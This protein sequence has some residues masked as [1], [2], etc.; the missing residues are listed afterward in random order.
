M[1][2]EIYL[3]F[4]F[5]LAKVRQVCVRAHQDTLHELLPVC[6]SKAQIRNRCPSTKA[7]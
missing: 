4:D 5:K 6:F 1:T 2:Q 3:N 7:S